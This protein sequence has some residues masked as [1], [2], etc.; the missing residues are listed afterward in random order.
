MKGAYRR[1]SKKLKFLIVC[2]FVVYA[3]M[4]A[5]V[6]AESFTPP[7]IAAEVV[8][9]HALAF[10]SALSQKTEYPGFLNCSMCRMYYF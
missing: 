1:C 7:N 6:Y 9:Q 2:A 10:T 4:P 5:T 8:T 3:A